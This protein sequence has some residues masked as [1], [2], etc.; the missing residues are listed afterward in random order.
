LPAATTSKPHV[1]AQSTSSQTIAGVAV[2]HRVHD[3]VASRDVV[4]NRPDDDVRLHRHHHDVHA[5]RQRAMRVSRAGLLVAGRFD[6]D[7][8][9]AIRRDVARLDER[10]ASALR[11]VVGDVR[12]RRVR[13]RVVRPPRRDRRVT[14]ALRRQIAEHA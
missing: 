14:C 9:V 6:Q 3:A 5:V 7:V 8:D 10:D 12:V 2:C 13:E 1:R 11:E 4:Q